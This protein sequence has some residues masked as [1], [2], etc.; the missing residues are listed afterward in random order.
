MLPGP[1]RPERALPLT[2]PASPLMDKCNYN[3]SSGDGH[4]ENGNYNDQDS[5]STGHVEIDNSYHTE[6]GA[7]ELVVNGPKSGRAA[8]AKANGTPTTPRPDVH[9]RLN[10]YPSLIHG[11][12]A[13]GDVEIRSHFVQMCC[14]TV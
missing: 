4:V 12:T 3:F 13:S 5:D 8:I 14:A 2:L 9:T 11:Q 6:T 10:Q 1:S 7:G